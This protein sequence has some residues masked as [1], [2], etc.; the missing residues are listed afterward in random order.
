MLKVD[1]G[2]MEAKSWQISRLTRK[3]DR[4]YDDP[5]K[6]HGTEKGRKKFGKQGA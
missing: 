1:V 2:E 6:C 3:Y 4:D 5:I